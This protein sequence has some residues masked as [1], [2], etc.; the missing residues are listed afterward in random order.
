[1]PN[2]EHHYTHKSPLIRASALGANDGII[3]I[4]GI[5]TAVVSSGANQE[6]ITLTTLS[7]LLAG[8]LSMGAGEYISVSTQLDSEKADIQREKRA[9]FENPE[10]EL[11]ELTKSYQV[12][13]LDKELASTVAKKLTEN[14][15]L[16]HH[17]QEE[18]GLVEEEL[19]RPILA[20]I[21]SFISF[22]IGGGI[23]SLLL[24]T[25]S[26][27]QILF[28]IYPI[29]L[30]CLL[31]LGLLSSILGGASPIKGALRVLILGVAVLLTSHFIGNQFL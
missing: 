7:A 13:G 18:L 9:L 24:L 30:G 2:I 27:D 8:A 20:S 10:L 14:D 28:W 4:A 25:N 11:E 3:S 16:K 19:S 22:S 29:T 17:L 31:S 21:I 23:P 6:Q 12:K 1:M 15:P 26:S 5:I